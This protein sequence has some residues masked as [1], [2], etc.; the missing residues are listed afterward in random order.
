MPLDSRFSG[1]STSSKSFYSDGNISID[2]IRDIARSIRKH[3]C[4]HKL[5]H[6][7]PKFTRKQCK[8]CHGSYSKYGK[9]YNYNKTSVRYHSSKE[10][11]E[12]PKVY[13][14]YINSSESTQKLP[15]ENYSTVSKKKDSCL[16]LKDED[17]FG[18]C[19][20]KLSFCCRRKYKY[21]DA[22]GELISNK[23]LQIVITVLI[24]IMAIWWV[25]FRI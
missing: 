3:E 6:N 20:T 5:S 7:S 14:A 10:K 8:N 23:L 16:W 18:N 15:D 9:Y 17:S 11:I 21:G 19:N 12:D 22:S 2:H 4:C 24:F 1:I 13:P 25:V